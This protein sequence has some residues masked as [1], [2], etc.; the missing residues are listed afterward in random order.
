MEIKVPS[1]GESVY[2]ATI[3]KWHK[4]DGERV[5]K[6]DLLCELETDKITLELNADADGVLSIRVPEGET[7]EIDAVIGAIEEGAGEKKEK[8]E[9]KEEKKEEKPPGKKEEKKA[10]K[11][12]EKK[13]EKPAPEKEAP[14]AKE[15]EKEEKAA[16]AAPARPAA[17]EAGRTRRQPMSRLRRRIAERLVAVRQQTAMLTTF[18]EADLTRILALRKKHGEAFEKRHGVRLGFMSFF[19]KACAEALKE[20]PEVNARIDGDDIVYHDYQH[21]GVAI[22]SGKGLVVPVVRDADGM[23]F[24]AIEQAVRDFAEKVESNRLDLSDLEGGTFTITNGGVYGSLLSTPILNP[25]QS[26]ILGMH[27][28]QERP[29]ARDG[30]I[31]I[32][33]MMY[34][35]LSYDHRLV[36]GREAVNFLKRIKEFV[37]EPDE[38]LLEL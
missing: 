2:E 21:I 17:E 15:A 35:A 27:V 32:R 26:A 31:V 34:L 29:V 33:P 1:V 7:V 24:A 20:F 11:K 5:E 16:K 36:D 12:A 8:E 22:G 19:V 4:Q 13:E 28:I 23:D 25:P 30:E 18:S 37:E 3:A 10:E 9:A 6:N 38:M 14:P